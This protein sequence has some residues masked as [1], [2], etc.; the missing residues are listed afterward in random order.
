M[1]TIKT[2][3]SN[4]KMNQLRGVHKMGNSN[5]IK[6]STVVIPTGKAAV[7]SNV[8]PMASFGVAIG[9]NKTASLLIDGIMDFKFGEVLKGTAPDGKIKCIAVRFSNEEG[10][11][12]WPV[13]VKHHRHGAGGVKVGNST[14]VKC[15]VDKGFQKGKYIAQKIDDNTLGF[16][17]KD[18]IHD[19]EKTQK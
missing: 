2:K 19:S 17:L 13:V 5:D 8:E 1:L 16:Y 15:L 11:N 3:Q 4:V 18:R 9:F 14:I 7:S 6:W 12:S 10:E